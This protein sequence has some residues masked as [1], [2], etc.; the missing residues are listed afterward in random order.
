MT[1]TAQ[2]T[3]APAKRSLSIIIPCHNEQELL[4]RTFA[5][6]VEAARRDLDEFEIILVND[7]SADKTGEIMA[8]LA[9]ANSEVVVVT[10]PVNINLAGIMRDGIKRSR[11][12]FIGI[13][14]GDY[15]FNIDGISRMFRGIGAADMIATYRLNQ[16]ATR[17]TL[18][19]VL[20]VVFNWL[21]LTFFRMPLRDV[22]SINSYRVSLLREIEILSAGPAFQIEILVKLF[23]RPIS[24]L[25]LP[26][27]LNPQKDAN[28]R[29]LSFKSAYAL[30]QV[31]L[32][33]W[34][35]RK[36]N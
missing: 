13:I 27:T 7:G 3:S 25:Q 22:H 26:V 17:S 34:L 35:D 20:T 21:M 30:A 5:E 14:P 18:R 33:L 9:A 16:K 29:T 4:P 6:I 19:Y 31:L 24:C 1:A 12:D 10:N 11:C 36:G 32:R 15:A 8:E 23:R 28:N 2:M